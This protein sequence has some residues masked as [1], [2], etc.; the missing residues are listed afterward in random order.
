MD[1]AIA[2]PVVT[3]WDRIEVDAGLVDRRGRLGAVALGVV[4]R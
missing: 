1:L 4:A 2:V 3:R